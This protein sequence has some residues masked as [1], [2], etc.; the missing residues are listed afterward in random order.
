MQIAPDEL[1]PGYSFANNTISI[2][3]AALPGL[4][5]GEANATTGNGM[6]ILRQIVDSAQAKISGLAPTARPTKGTIAKPNPSIASGQGV[7]PGTLS[8]SYTLTFQLQ[9]TGLELAA[10]AS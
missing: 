6:E 1:F 9:P 2:P 8:Q 10:E 7:E 5:A 3:L 4:S